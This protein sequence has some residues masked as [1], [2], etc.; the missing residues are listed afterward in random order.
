MYQVIP[1]IQSFIR[2]NLSTAYNHALEDYQENDVL[3][4]PQVTDRLLSR[5]KDAF[6]DVDQGG[7]RFNA[8]TFT[9]RGRGSE[10]SRYGADFGGFLR[11]DYPNYRVRKFL[12][13]QA[14]IGVVQNGNI[15]LVNSPSELSRMLDQLQRMTTITL[16]S[17]LVIYTTQ[18]FVFVPVLSILN[19]TPSVNNRDYWVNLVKQVPYFQTID[20][21]SNYFG[22]ITGDT[23]LET[24]AGFS[25]DN[26][27][28]FREA[29]TALQARPPERILELR[30]SVERQYPFEDTDLGHQ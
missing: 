13:A 21:F 14:K 27:Q 24:R 7:V 11:I 22:C 30:A 10:E 3:H 28:A 9:D 6:N 25:V 1:E 2:N 8:V 20:L 26:V 4:E 5:L 23:T 15:G 18:D 19:T 16:E 12:L 17:Y 29:M